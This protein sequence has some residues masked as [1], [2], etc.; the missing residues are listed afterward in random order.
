M[1][2]QFNVKQA[3]RRKG[4]ISFV[5]LFKIDGC[6]MYGHDT[7]TFYLEITETGLAKVGDPLSRT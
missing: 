4:L 2:E 6:R 5:R 3:S 1:V 7:G